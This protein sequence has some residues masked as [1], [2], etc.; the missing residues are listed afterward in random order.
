MYPITLLLQSTAC[1]AQKYLAVIS[2]INIKLFLSLWI[3]FKILSGFRR[4]FSLDEFSVHGPKHNIFI[5][6]IIKRTCMIWVGIE[7]TTKIILR[8]LS[9]PFFYSF[10]PSGSCTFLLLLTNYLLDTIVNNSPQFKMV[11]GTAW[12]CLVQMWFL[13]QGSEEDLELDTQSKQNRWQ[14]ILDGIRPSSSCLR[15]LIIKHFVTPSFTL[16]ESKNGWI[17]SRR[18]PNVWWM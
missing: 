13:E 17:R 18:W 16:A 9:C 14:N 7:M 15:H 8:S 5:L 12:S 6:S 3:F 2:G 1:S 4:A 10:M 11:N